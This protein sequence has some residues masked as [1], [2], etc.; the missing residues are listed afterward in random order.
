MEL[1]VSWEG[2]I[3]FLILLF[4]RKQRAIRLSSKK[5]LVNLKGARK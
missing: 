1:I 3:L 2:D 4:E 5:L